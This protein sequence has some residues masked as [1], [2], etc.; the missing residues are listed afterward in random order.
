M[1]TLSKIIEGLEMVD[2]I[3]E[4]YYNPEKDEIFLSNI[5]E[6]EELTEDEIEELFEKSIILPTQY[7]INEYQI[8]VD[9]IDTINN[10]EIKNNL[11]RLIQGKGAFRRF[12]DYCLEINIIQDWYDFKEEKY[13]EIAINWCEQNELKYK[14]DREKLKLI[15]ASGSKPRQ[16]ILKNI[17]LKYEVKKSLVEEKSNSREPSEYVKDLSKDKANSVAFQIDEKA[18]IISADSI[19]YM[20]GKIYEKPKNKEEAYQN[21]KEM[22]GK[23]T[24]A[25]TGVTIKDLYQNKEI[26]FSDTAEVYMRKISDDDIKWYVEN[27]ENILNRCGYAMLGKASL[28]LNKVNGDYNTLF[29]ISPSKVYEKL[30]ELGYKISDFELE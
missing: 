21:M 27:E 18:I 30:K 11:Q 22:S 9:F 29:G 6:Y 17:G 23:V 20:D 14:D 16:D 10:L 26:C 5:G 4:C 13:K 19:I 8:M 7:E 12:K 15:L 3:V 24:Y 1:V 28:F 25:I 2:D